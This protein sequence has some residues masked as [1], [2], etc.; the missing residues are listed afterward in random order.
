MTTQVE[1]ARNGIITAQME[2][3]ARSEGVDMGSLLSSVA[4]G[5]AVIMC[6]DGKTVGIGKG[7]RTK[8]N[9][10]IGTSSLKIDPDEEVR[11]A[12]IGEKYG[13]DTLSDLSM[14]GD[15]TEIRKKILEN[16]T[17]PLTTVP[18]Y[19]TAAQIGLENMTEDDL[20]RNLARQAEEGVSSFVLHCT[21]S[22][23]LNMLKDKERILGV[24]S[25]A[26]LLPALIWHQ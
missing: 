13:A 4:Q 20:L 24:V 1:H 3:V 9:V 15:I 23:T 5:S 6:R 22:A 17:I 19:Q 25:K 14:G 21:D 11:K 2:E 16:T 10:N 26:G 12:I 7:L 8:V 18:I